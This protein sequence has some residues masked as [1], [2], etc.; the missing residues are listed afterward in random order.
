MDFGNH[1]GFKCIDKEYKNLVVGEWYE[2]IRDENVLNFKLNGWVDIVLP[3]GSIGVGNGYGFFTYEDETLG[4]DHND[5]YYF[6]YSVG[7]VR[8][9]K[10][11][12]IGI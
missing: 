12:E 7:E 2:F 6:F 1:T 3:N 5:F 11:N 4:H 9:M 10:L 8:D